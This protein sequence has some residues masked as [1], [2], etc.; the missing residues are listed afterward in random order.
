MVSLD[1]QIAKIRAARFLS[2]NDIDK[3]LS[4]FRVRSTAMLIVSGV[5]L[6]RV[7]EWGMGFAASC[8]KTGVEIAAI[9]AAVQVPATFYAGWVFKMYQDGKNK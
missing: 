5:M 1:Y 6:W 8:L 9:I 7:S 3:W 4:R 2:M